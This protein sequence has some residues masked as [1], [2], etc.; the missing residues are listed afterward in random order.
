MQAC[1]CTEKGTRTLILDGPQILIQRFDERDE[2]GRCPRLCVR[3]VIKQLA[4][5]ACHARAGKRSAQKDTDMRWI[6]GAMAIKSSE[7]FFTESTCE[8]R[9]VLQ[10]VLLDFES[11]FH[12]KE[13]G[14]GERGQEAAMGKNEN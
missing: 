1:R 6:R 10:T 3:V 7:L 4:D 2:C 14:R 11:P 12:R 9:E 13:A 8:T 5:A